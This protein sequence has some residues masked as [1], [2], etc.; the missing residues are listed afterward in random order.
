M[1]KI[2]DRTRVFSDHLLLLI[3]NFRE[4]YTKNIERIKAPKRYYN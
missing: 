2:T 1:A 3:E 4:R